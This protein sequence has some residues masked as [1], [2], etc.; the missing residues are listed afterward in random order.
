VANRL[1]Y[2]V[3]MG[4]GSLYT[5]L[6]QATE[7][8]DSAVNVAPQA[9]AWTDTGFTNDGL[10]LMLNQE[11]AT[12][13][14]D[15]VADILGRKMTSR[16]VQVKTNLAEPTLQNLTL[17]LNSGTITSGSGPAAWSK[18]TPVFSGAE[19]QPTY[20]ASILDGYAPSSPSG[21]SKRRRL[22]MRRCLSIDNVEVAYKKDEL[23]LVPVT[24]GCHFVDTTTAPFV[25]VDEQ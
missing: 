8:A 14:V 6:Y 15:Q 12:M 4:A 5:G 11:F 22:I 1:A 19:L 20:F 24:L 3:V 7:P 21:V 23:T 18:Y 10:S 17:G 9:S 16:D 13:A 25:I 2:Q